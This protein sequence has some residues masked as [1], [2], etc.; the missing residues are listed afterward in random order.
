MKADELQFVPAVLDTPAAALGP[1]RKALRC[2]AKPDLGTIEIEVDGIIIRAGRHADAGIG[3]TLKILGIRRG[4]IACDEKRSY[5]I[6]SVRVLVAA[7]RELSRLFRG[8]LFPYSLR[9]AMNVAASR[10]DRVAIAVCEAS[11]TMRS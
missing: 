4:Q 1:E 10:N 3:G 8:R 7:V 2:K 6:V 11:P 5:A 9:L